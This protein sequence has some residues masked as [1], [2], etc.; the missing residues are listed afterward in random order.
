MVAAD[1]ANTLHLFRIDDSVAIPAGNHRKGCPPLMGL[2]EKPMVNQLQTIKLAVLTTT[3]HS[4]PL[5][6]II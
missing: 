1:D 5:L 6:I 3:K 4:Y 2:V